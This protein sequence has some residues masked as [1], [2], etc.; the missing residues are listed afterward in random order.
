MKLIHFINFEL[1]RGTTYWEATGGYTGT[2]TFIIYTVL[3]K[4]ERMRLERHMKEYD[5]N[6]FM[7]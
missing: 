4:Y 2:K 7:I 1:K 3:S 6:A 5:P